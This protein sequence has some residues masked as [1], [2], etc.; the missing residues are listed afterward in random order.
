MASVGQVVQIIITGNSDQ[1]I[2]SIEKLTATTEASTAK[3]AA[4]FANFGKAATLG[5]VAAGGAI[6]AFGIKQAMEQETA[7]AKLKTAINNTGAA[8]ADYTDKIDIS[9]NLFDDN[10]HKLLTKAAEA[11]LSRE[12]CTVR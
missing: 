6:A 2:A 7:T 1:A 8:Y 5:L 12:V 10:M 11:I 4:S 3:A 9:K